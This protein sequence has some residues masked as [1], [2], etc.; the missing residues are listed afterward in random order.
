[1]YERVFENLILLELFLPIPQKIEETLKL[2][3]EERQE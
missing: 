3:N 2:Q 1:M